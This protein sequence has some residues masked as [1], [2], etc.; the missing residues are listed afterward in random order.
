MFAC[1]QQVVYGIHGVCNIVRTET[2]IIDRKEVEYFV[3]TPVEQ[4]ETSFYVPTNNATA[5]SKLKPIL[6][7]EQLDLLLCSDKAVED[8]W[9]QDENNRKQ[10]YRELINSGNRAALISMVRTLL[11]HKS[12][13]A[14]VGRKF[15]LCD[16]NFL[17][18]AQKLLSSEFSLVL[19]IPKEAVGEYIQSKIG[20]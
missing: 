8:A 18:D 20:K 2:R 4:P 10:R 17:R 14:A 11:V 16:E 1:G 3:L 5:L 9:I 6:T 15:H 12:K 19:N 7:K 13:Q